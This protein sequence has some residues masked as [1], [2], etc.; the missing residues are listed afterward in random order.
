MKSETIDDVLLACCTAE[1]N[2]ACAQGVTEEEKT[3]VR[4]LIQYLEIHCG[5]VEDFKL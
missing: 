3:A 4:N 1:S 2:L 5:V